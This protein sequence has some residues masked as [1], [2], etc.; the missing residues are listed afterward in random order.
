MHNRSH[1]QA[2]LSAL[3][4]GDLQRA[5]ERLNAGVP[6]RF[7]AVYRL[8]ETCLVNRAFVDKQGESL[9]GL[10]ARVP[11]DDSFCRFVLRDGFFE[12]VDSSRDDRLT[13]SPYQGLLQSYVAA[14]I[15]DSTGNFVIGSLCHFDRVPRQA[16]VADVDLLKRAGRMISARMLN[17]PSM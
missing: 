1:V 8:E 6:Y 14:P 5:L 17:Q 9:D 7:S 12:T 3:S 4:A 13:G 2:V 10:L 11:L 15:T 16:G